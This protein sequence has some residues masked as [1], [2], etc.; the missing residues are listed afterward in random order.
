MFVPSSG[1][2]LAAPEAL[3]NC[4]EE[5]FAWDS[6]ALIRVQ[7]NQGRLRWTEEGHEIL[8][9]HQYNAKQIFN[10]EKDD[11][12]ARA[13]IG[14]YLWPQ[15]PTHALQIDPLCSSVCYAGWHTPILSPRPGPKQCFGA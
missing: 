13:W 5:P 2:Y 15:D 7:C 4:T 6:G 1:Q 14:V 8:T 11:A 10:I 3:P 12:G 9:N